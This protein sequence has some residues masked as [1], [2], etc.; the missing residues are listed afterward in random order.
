MLKRRMI[1]TGLAATVIVAMNQAG[2]VRAAEPNDDAGKPMRQVT[3]EMIRSLPVTSVADILKT[4]VGITVRPDKFYVRGT[5]IPD[6]TFTAQ[7]KPAP[8]W[9]ML[10]FY[11]LD[12]GS[13]P[14]GMD[15][16]PSELDFDL[17]D[18]GDFDLLDVV[19]A[20]NDGIRLTRWLNSIVVRPAP[21][22]GPKR[23]DR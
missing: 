16:E 23:R 6:L 15:G 19:I 9:Q 5:D 8:T 22:T 10:D 2:S 20:A 13:W 4:Q 11:Y 3:A 18:D 12:G 17:N 1:I 14:P 21:Y 7:P